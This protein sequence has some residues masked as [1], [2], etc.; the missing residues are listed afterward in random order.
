MS[1]DGLECLVRTGTVLSGGGD[2]MA[3]FFAA[4]TL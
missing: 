4:C 1:V 2:D 3:V